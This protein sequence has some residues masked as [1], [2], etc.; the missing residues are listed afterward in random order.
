MSEKVQ[1]HSKAENALF[2]ATNG[3]KAVKR[4]SC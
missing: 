2:L 3:T 1:K 4:Q